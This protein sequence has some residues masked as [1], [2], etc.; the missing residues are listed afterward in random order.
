MNRGNNEIEFN[1]SD[2]PQPLCIANGDNYGII[3]EGFEVFLT[4]QDIAFEQC[5]GL[6]KKPVDLT[7][8][9]TICFFTTNSFPEKVKKI[10]NFDYSNLEV[11]V[12]IGGYAVDLVRDLCKHH[13]KQLLTYNDAYEQIFVVE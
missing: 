2:L 7:K 12:A 1:P 4:A 10:M 5:Y 8:Y 13:K 3:E 9:K 6:Y 11:V